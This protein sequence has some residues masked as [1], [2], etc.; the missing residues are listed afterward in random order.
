MSLD[1]LL[2]RLPSH[3]D[4]SPDSNN[5]KAMLL[6]AKH[7][8]DIEELY[9]TILK[10]WDVDQA[11]GN[12]LDRLGKD[13][14]IS[15]GSFDDETYRKM[16]KIQYIINLSNGEIESIN[17]ILKAYL[18][19]SFLYIEEGWERHNEPASFF[20]NVSSLKQDF[21]YALLQKIKAA[22]VA[23]KV[24]L[25]QQ[26]VLNLYF[27]G[28]ISTR[29]KIQIRPAAFKMPS[30]QQTKYYAGF[31]SMRSRTIIKSEV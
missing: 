11:E 9:T 6:A 26:D 23:A 30:I 18:G 29:N 8:E 12:G 28:I 22:G 16:I 10:F 14:G 27:G 7:I 2:R 24:T 17:S 1:T 15:R 19:D 31:I 5:Y 3:F 25:K 20:V 13:E 21:P 4:K